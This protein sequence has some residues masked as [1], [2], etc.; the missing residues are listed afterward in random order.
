MSE[1]N[2][3]KVTVCP[4]RGTYTNV[5]YDVM[6]AEKITLDNKTRQMLIDHSLDIIQDTFHNSVKS[7]INKVIEEDKYYNWY[8][9]FTE[10]KNPYYQNDDNW[11]KEK[12]C[13][14]RDLKTYHRFYTAAS[15]GSIFSQDF[16][17][18]S[19]KDE[20]GTYIEVKIFV[21]DEINETANLQLH[22]ELQEMPDKGSD[23]ITFNGEQID[24]KKFSKSISNP[25]ESYNF[26][27]DLT[28]EFELKWSYNN[29]AHSQS[30]YGEDEWTVEFVRFNI[31]C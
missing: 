22:L 28:D 17:T 8:R 13:N 24:V 20:V 3:P 11:K 7:Q 16:G 4:P 1:I 18:K 5:N 9:G 12:N 15:S 21:P 31:R 14:F 26:T 30:K 6:Q 10:I 29:D 25:T 19:E 27:F 2:F 23:G